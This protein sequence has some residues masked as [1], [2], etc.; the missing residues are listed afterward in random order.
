[1]MEFK[2]WLMEEGSNPGVKTGLYPL[3]YGGIGLYPPSWYPTRSADAIY[4]MSIDERI[5]KG[6]DGGKFDITHLPPK[7]KETMSRG[8]QGT[9]DITHLKGGPTH[10]VGSEYAAKSGDGGAWDITGI[11]KSQ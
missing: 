9:W 11:K 8:D 1:M 5:Y 3:G 2:K 4:Y 6:K 10:K 7:S